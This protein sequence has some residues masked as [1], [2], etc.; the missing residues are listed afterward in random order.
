MHTYK[1]QLQRKM[2]VA[3]SAL[4][5]II[6]ILYLITLPLS[7]LWLPN[8]TRYGE[9]SREVLTSRD[10]LLPHIFEFSQFEKPVAGYWLNSIS[11]WIFGHDNVAAA[12]AVSAMAT[13]LT[14]CLVFRMNMAIRQ[15]VNQA[16][17]VKLV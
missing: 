9:I 8:E 6:F 4:I 7:P 1:H 10:W 3:L 13:V 15:D 5:C 11:Q 16:L 17:T 14:A 2:T 12:R